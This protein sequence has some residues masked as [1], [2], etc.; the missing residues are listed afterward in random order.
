MMPSTGTLLLAPS[1]P[2]H[3]ELPGAAC[4]AIQDFQKRRQGNTWSGP[5]G[6]AKDSSGRVMRINSCLSLVTQ[7]GDKILNAL[8]QDIYLPHNE[9][10]LAKASIVQAGG[11]QAHVSEPGASE[12]GNKFTFHHHLGSSS[13]FIITITA[14]PIY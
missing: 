14:V 1:L 9:L 6:P 8:R 13:S 5:V 10:P 2:D 3:V 11:R 7:L 12:K 4:L